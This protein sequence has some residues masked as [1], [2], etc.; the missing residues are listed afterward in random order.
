MD[1]DGPGI[2]ITEKKSDEHNSLKLG[3]R[4]G[5]DTIKLEVWINEQLNAVITDPKLMQS[6]IIPDLG[7][8][9]HYIKILSY[10][11]FFNHSQYNMVHTVKD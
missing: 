8:G 4:T 3:L 7:K 9:S 10:D 5:D 11:C 1:S 2:K 6:V